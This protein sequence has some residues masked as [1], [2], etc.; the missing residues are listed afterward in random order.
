MK[1][2]EN[3]A[4]PVNLVPA[5]PAEEGHWVSVDSGQIDTSQAGTH[6]IEYTAYD[7][8]GNHSSV[9][10]TVVVVDD[11]TVPFIAL[12]G[13]SIYRHE[14]GEVFVD[15]EAI[16]TD[17]DD[18]ELKTDLE[19]VGTVDVNVLGQYTLTYDY[20]DSGS[21]KSAESVVRTVVVEDSTVPEL[22]LVEHPTFGGTD[23]VELTVGEEWVD[24]GITLTDADSAAWYVSSREYIPNKLIMA[25]I[26]GNNTMID[27]NNNG[28]LLGVTPRGSTFLTP[29][30][31]V[32]G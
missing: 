31:V 14:L 15:P 25:G 29:V 3:G 17:A 1:F 18:N 13:D 2:A 7:V 30:R 22:A 32:K 8:A 5:D 10:R 28:G 26:H 24:P 11:A 12:K 20:T 21:G 16:V 27:F 23:T 6:T 9:F 4:I 19:G